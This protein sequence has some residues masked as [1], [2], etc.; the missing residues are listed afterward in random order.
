MLGFDAFF[1]GDENDCQTI[2]PENHALDLVA[3]AEI[4]PKAHLS[5]TARCEAVVGEHGIFK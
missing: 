4:G 1:S 5:F 2:L 3:K